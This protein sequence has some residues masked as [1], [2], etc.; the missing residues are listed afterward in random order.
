MK[1]DKLLH[2][3]NKYDFLY[4]QANSKEWPDDIVISI[5]SVNRYLPLIVLSKDELDANDYDFH[6]E[7]LHNNIG[8]LTLKSVLDAVTAYVRTPIGKRLPERK[9]L[10]CLGKNGY[11]SKIYLTKIDGPRKIGT[12]M[13]TGCFAEW[14]D[15]ELQDLVGQ[16]PNLAP[17]IDD[18]MEEV[19]EDKDGAC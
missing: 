16:F 11:G 9:W 19:K 3:I 17:A 6:T 18:M 14:N 5:K 7:N 13:K 4:A 1:L 12:T 2:E 10:L 8:P 15:Q